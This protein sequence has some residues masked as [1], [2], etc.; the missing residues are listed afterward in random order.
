MGEFTDVP[1]API[2]Q[3]E[4]TQTDNQTDNGFT[5]DVPD[6]FSND[7]MKQ[8]ASE[9]P[10]FDCSKDE[11]YQNMQHGR[12]RLRF[13]SGTPQQKYMSQT[14]YN[15]AFF[16]RHTDDNGKSYTRKVK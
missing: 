14:K 2:N 16:I 5:T 12:K 13:K 8:G 7:V 9:F 6:V 4:P 11:F 1:T 3:P 10:V 15:K